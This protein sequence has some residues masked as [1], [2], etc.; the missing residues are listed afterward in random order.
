MNDDTRS[1]GFFTDLYQAFNGRAVDTVLAVLSPQ[2]EWAN[3]WEGGFV[4]GRAAVADYWDRQWQ[5]L[6]PTVTPVSVRAVGQRYLVRVHQV[7]RDMR[8]QLAH[9]ATVEH[10]YTFD[11]SGLITR[12]EI[13][14]VP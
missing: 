2:V 3:G 14:D 6:D 4:S 1:D 7:V 11:D 8:G 12:M 9:E 13:H 5:E 10:V